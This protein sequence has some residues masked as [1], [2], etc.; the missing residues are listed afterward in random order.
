MTPPPVA[1]TQGSQ[2][3]GHVETAADLANGVTLGGTGEPGAT[4]RVEVAGAVQTATVG[5]AGRLERDLSARGGGGRRTQP[6]RYGDGDRCKLGNRTVVTETLV[7][8]TVGSPVMALNPVTSDDVL[9]ATETADGFVITGTTTPF[10]TVG[11]GAR[12]DQPVDPGRSE[13]A[14]DDERRVAGRL[15]PPGEYDATITATTVDAAGNTS[16]VTQG[17][18]IDTSTSVTLAGPVAGDDVVTAV[19][20]AAGIRAD[21]DGRSRGPRSA[22][23]GAALALPATVA[24]NGMPGRSPFRAARCRRAIRSA[25]SP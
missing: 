17:I 22:W 6:A 11:R 7:V 2:A 19:E 14:V 24:P 3:A 20:A 16:S 18:R 13:R 10:A 8:D 4:I 12:P 21:R 15:L 1:V 23:P 9:N 25:P 5:G